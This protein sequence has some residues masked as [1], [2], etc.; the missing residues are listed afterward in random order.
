MAFEIRQAKQLS[1]ALAKE[2]YA[3]FA[4]PLW[5]GAVNLL[6]LAGG[7]TIDFLLVAPMFG[8]RLVRTD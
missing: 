8:L 2:P 3:E 4:Q 7:S 5:N 6:E 1:A